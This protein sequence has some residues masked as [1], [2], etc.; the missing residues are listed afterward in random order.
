MLIDTDIEQD[1]EVNGFVRN[2][3]NLFLTPILN[4]LPKR[5]FI[6]SS[7]KAKT[8]HE[9]VTTHT[10]LEVIYSFNNELNFQKG[11]LEGLITYFWQTT[12]SAKA[13]RN[14]LK[15]VKKEVDKAIS[16]L[17]KKKITVLNLACGSNV[18]VFETVAKYKNIL[19]IDVFGVDRNEKAIIDAEK[20][21]SGFGIGNVFKG[22]QNTISGFLNENKHLKF[23]IIEMVGFLDYVE[24]AKA[25]E[26]FNQIHSALKEDGVFI[27]GNVSDNS[28]RR[29]ITE[30][31]GW[32]RLIFRDEKDL[33]DLISSS[34]FNDC[35]SRIVYEPQNIHAVV[36]CHKSR[37][38]AVQKSKEMGM[39]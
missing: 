4:R 20:L 7:R 3:A 32:P 12:N 21:A 28:E 30:V 1:Y 24:D 29:F 5:V 34:K 25:I 15:L 33:A 31:V 22:C 13:L 11:V 9:H 16:S 18:A 19:S 39:D 37:P 27:T 10:A 38:L 35:E 23:D 14:R 36:I 6:G 8:V 26:L 2:T 17:N